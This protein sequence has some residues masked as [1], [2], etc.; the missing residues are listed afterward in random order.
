MAEIYDML[1]GDQELDELIVELQ[2]PPDTPLGAARARLWEGK[3]EEAA[4]LAAGTGEPWS[5][6][7]VSEARIR[8]GLGA[9]RTLLAIAEDPTFETRARLWA[10]TALRRIGEK[11]SAFHAGEVLGFVVEV[12]M[13]GRRDVLAAYADGSARFLGFAGQVIAREA[14]GNI[15]ATT[16]ALLVEARVL[17]KVPAAPRQSAPL[18]P[19]RV[20]MTAISAN[21]THM[22]EVPWSEVEPP[23]KYAAVFTAA[24]KLL[25]EVTTA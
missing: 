2:A 24:A 16:D 4:A 7:I 10:W 5:S 19:D 9:K 21:G 13:G 15:D 23:A 17:L 25:Q 11:P 1:F 8:G 20:R 6:F 18:P 22:V 14:N 3:Y 12:P